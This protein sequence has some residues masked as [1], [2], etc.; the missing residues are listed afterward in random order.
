MLDKPKLNKDTWKMLDRNNAYFQFI[1]TCK[2]KQYDSNVSLHVHHI[3]P[4]YVLNKTADGRAYMNSPENLIV[5]SEEDHIKAHTLLFEIYGNQ[6]DK[7]ACLMLKGAMNESRT[8][9]YEEETTR[10]TSN[11]S[12][13]KRKRNNCL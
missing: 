13:S 4:Q 8:S 5:L 2:A 12:N 6:N 3:I 11:S 7:G 9:T 10:C 1:D